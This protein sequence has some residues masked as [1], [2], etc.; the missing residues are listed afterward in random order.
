[1]M[2]NEFGISDNL[3]ILRKRYGLSQQELAEIAGVTNKAVSAWETGK[4]EPR[5]GAIER[6]SKHFNIKKSNL[7]EHG[8]MDILGPDLSNAIALSF[9]SEVFSEKEIEDIVNYIN[10]VKAKRN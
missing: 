3:K 8:G 2:D 7:I 5:M 6:I 9:G 10:Y 4:K 1:M